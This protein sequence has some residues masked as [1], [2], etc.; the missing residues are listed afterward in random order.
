MPT[1]A[2]DTASVPAPGRRDPDSAGLVEKDE[3][4]GPAGGASDRRPA[5]RG[6]T[7]QRART[8]LLAP[9]LG[10]LLP[11]PRAAKRLVNLYR[12]LR[13]SLAEAELPEFVGGQDGG[14]YQAAAILLAVVGRP[15]DA[16]ALLTTLRHTNRDGEDV[17]NFLQHQDQPQLAELIDTIRK[18]T[19]IHGDVDTYQKWGRTVARFSFETYDLFLAD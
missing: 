2:E 12:L 1:Q 15:S 19:P 17:V 8:G 5:T 14:P 6:V 9:R 13:I 11:T 4:P 7:P 10:L 18:D 3:R 16:R